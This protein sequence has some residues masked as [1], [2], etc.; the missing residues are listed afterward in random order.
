M[1]TDLAVEGELKKTEMQIAKLAT[2]LK[3]REGNKSLQTRENEK[4]IRGKERKAGG[5]TDRH[6][7]L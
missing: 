6:T 2:R 4:Q 3:D 1:L 5:E 7:R